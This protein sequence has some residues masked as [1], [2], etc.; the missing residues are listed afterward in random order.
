MEPHTFFIDEHHQNK[1]QDTNDVFLTLDTGNVIS[2]SVPSSI[3][4]NDFSHSYSA[5]SPEMTSQFVSIPDDKT[6]DSFNLND[7]DLFLAAEPQDN[8]NLQIGE[9]VVFSA[10]YVP[11]TKPPLEEKAILVPETLELNIFEHK[12]TAELAEIVEEKIVRDLD[13]QDVEQAAAPIDEDLLF[14][15]ENEEIRSEI[16]NV[17]TSSLFELAETKSEAIE[18]S[19]LENEQDAFTQEVEGSTSL[20]NPAHIEEIL[21]QENA[22]DD[23]TQEVEASTSLENLA[24]I[25]ENLAQ[26]NEPVDVKEKELQEENSFILE[27]ITNEP[28]A[29]IAHTPS[30]SL[31]EEEAEY[32]STFHDNYDMLIYR[33]GNQL[34]Q[35]PVNEEELKQYFDTSR[36][37]RKAT[38][39]EILRKETSNLLENF[40][41][42]QPKMPKMNPNDANKPVKVK[43]E[44]EPEPEILTETMAKIH[45]LQGN[46]KEAVEIYEKLSLVFPEKSVYFADQIQKIM[47]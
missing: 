23:F 9:N 33:K 29:E 3:E 20:E 25:V 32:P 17:S 16:S 10:N 47:K 31:F 26:E 7:Y 24:P 19:L 38:A 21:L 5:T 22:Q 37:H 42:K 41:V 8:L 6:T 28:F 43:E 34:I 45:L 14:P 2:N 39:P 35:I 12:K 18:E 30:P 27:E 15:L 4:V 44:S 13:K 36:I 40:L 1:E 11:T 46:K